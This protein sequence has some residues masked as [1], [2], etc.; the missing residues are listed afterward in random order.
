MTKA[1]ERTHSAAGGGAP[2]VERARQPV[3]RKASRDPERTRASV[4]AAATRT[5]VESGFN[6]ARIDRIAERAGVN[7]QLIYYYFGS[8][9]QLYVAVLDAAYSALR[10]AEADLH[11]A[12]LDP[13]DGMRELALFNWRYHVA[14]PDLISLV[15]TENLHRAKYLK[16][17]RKLT[18][19]NSP[20]IAAISALLERGARSGQFRADSD[21]VDVYISI[22][23]LS[24]YYLANQWTLA[25]NFK[26]K[27][28][29]PERLDAWGEHIVEVILAY[30]RPRTG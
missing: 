22:A 21:P 12:D 3:R 11:L 14:H 16:R 26:R 1:L 6:G 10:L 23:A 15:R 30:L 25:V 13:V 5:F 7:K 29:A 2:P 24:F 9:E 8:K 4:L 17:S 18:D 19:L 20:L 27:L 28:L